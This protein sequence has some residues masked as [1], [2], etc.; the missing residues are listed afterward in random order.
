MLA[1]DE[2]CKILA[3]LGLDHVLTSLPSS[4]PLVNDQIM[5]KVGAFELIMDGIAAA[6]RNNIRVSVNHV[7]SLANYKSVYE[8]AK[9]VAEVGGQKIF[10]T[11]AVHATY[12]KDPEKMGI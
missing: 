1:T 11:K 3:D 12:S 9:K 7:V 8:T 5:Q 2:K 4:D 10:I 6:R